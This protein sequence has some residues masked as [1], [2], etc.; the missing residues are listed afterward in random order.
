MNVNKIFVKKFMWLRKYIFLIVL[1]SMN[2]F[3]IL[4]IIYVDMEF[5]EVW[6]KVYI[7][8]L[9]LCKYLRRKMFCVFNVINLFKFFI[10]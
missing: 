6:Y 1:F 8:I 4:Y 7:S 10:L 5:I 2:F 9:W 3:V